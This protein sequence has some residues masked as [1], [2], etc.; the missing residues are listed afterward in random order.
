M[1]T[2]SFQFNIQY[3]YVSVFNFTSVW[4]SCNHNIHNDVL[5]LKSFLI[6]RYGIFGNITVCSTKTKTKTF[7]NMTFCTLGVE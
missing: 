2:I 3:M 5:T 4:L 7:T 6:H 1:L